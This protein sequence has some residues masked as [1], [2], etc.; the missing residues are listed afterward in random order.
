MIEPDVV[1]TCPKRAAIPALI[2][3]L[4]T[5][6]GIVAW[7][8]LGAHP[9]LWRTG[10]PAWIL[11]GAGL[12]TVFYAA[13]RDSRW[14]VRAPT[15]VSVGLSLLFVYGFFVFAALPAPQGFEELDTAPDFALR[16]HNKQ[17]VSLSDS[18]SAGPVLLVF[19]R[20]HW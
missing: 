6:G 14:L 19:Y 15:I 5:I 12:L 9:W 8:L 16:D 3:M 18:L 11:I 4:L 17:T 10:L 1:Q 13:G 7:V 2:G 20:G